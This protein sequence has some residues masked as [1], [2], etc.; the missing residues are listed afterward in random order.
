MKYLVPFLF[1]LTSIRCGGLE[2]SSTGEEISAFTPTK[3]NP[4]GMENTIAINI[5]IYWAGIKSN[6]CLQFSAYLQLSSFRTK[7][8]EAPWF[9]ERK[10]PQLSEKRFFC[11]KIFY[12]VAINAR[13][14]IT[15]QEWNN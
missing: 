10:L 11:E 13:I 8:V 1:L 2:Y 7:D 3:K 9:L 15:L 12:R 5:G 14:N 6:F 4:K